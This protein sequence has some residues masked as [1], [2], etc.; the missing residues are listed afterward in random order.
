MH[1]QYLSQIPIKGNYPKGK[2]EKSFQK[3]FFN[4][5]KK[6][7]WITYHIPDIWPWYRFL[8]AICI[9]PEWDTVYIEFK[10][11]DWYT[12]NFTQYEGSQILLLNQLKDRPNCEAYTCIFSQKTNTYVLYTFSELL[13]LR[14]DKWGCKLFSA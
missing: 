4:T 12:F 14:N 6:H 2:I 5:L 13:A 3:D 11:T 7:N 9:S 10:K 1:R 8:D